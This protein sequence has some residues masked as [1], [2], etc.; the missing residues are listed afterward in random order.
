[1]SDEQWQVITGDCAAVMRDR[2]ADGAID[3]TVTSPPYD[4]LRKYNG[5]H[6]DF[7]AIA[8]QLWR[9][10]KPGGVVVWVVADATI[11]GSET[12]TSFRQ[13]L[14]F[15][16]L[17]FNLHDTM[18]YEVAGTGAKGSNYAYWQA[19]EFMYVFSKGRP[20]K[21]NRLSDRRNKQAGKN[22]STSTKYNA[23]G[24]RNKGGGY[25]TAENGV[26]TNIWRYAVGAN[27]DDPSE[28]PAPFPEALARDH[29]I[30]WSNPGDV[31]LDPMCGSGTTGK[32]AVLLGRRFIGI[33]IS[34][35]YVEGIARPRIQAAAEQ[36][37]QLTL[38]IEQA[39]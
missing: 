5:Y 8:A 34:S 19:Y 10:T 3:L 25:V 36:A 13:A 9:V 39:A 4:N 27:G 31:V 26:R 30:S 11:K 17:G 18:I 15:M 14:H 23:L 6:F 7:E 2:I 22:Q 32:Q 16:G 29:I 38:G 21:V 33:D 37:R 35:E 28:H 12:G 1:M 20:A 24:T